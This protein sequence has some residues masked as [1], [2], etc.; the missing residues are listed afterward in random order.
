MTDVRVVV[1][2]GDCTSP[3]M[4]VELR[5]IESKMGKWYDLKVRGMVG[6][7]RND[8]GATPFCMQRE[9]KTTLF[10]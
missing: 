8:H 1:R 10:T 6:S 9:S 3:G 4:D 5:K 7:A 2:G